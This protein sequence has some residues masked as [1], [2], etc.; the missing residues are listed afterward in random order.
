VQSWE[1]GGV[2]AQNLPVQ[3]LCLREP[4][5]A[6]RRHALIEKLTQLHL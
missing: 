3:A 4:P 1:T 5:G 6:M 2:G